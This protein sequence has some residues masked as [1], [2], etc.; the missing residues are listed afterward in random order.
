MRNTATTGAFTVRGLPAQAE[1]E[2]LGEKR[3]VPI[4][5]GRFTDAFRPYD[6][7][8]YRILPTKERKER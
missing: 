2:V 4:Q 3:F 8:L 5:N 1:A 7:H 6:V